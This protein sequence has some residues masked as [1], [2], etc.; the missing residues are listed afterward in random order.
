MRK[1]TLLEMNALAEKHG[2]KCLSKRYVT[3]QHKLKWQCKNGHVWTSLPSSVKQGFWCD[4]CF[5]DKRR[6][7]ISQMQKVASLRGGWCLSK[8]Y[9]NADEALKWKCQQGHVWK[10]IPSSV[11]R[12]SWCQRCAGKAKHSI[13]EM[14]ALAQKRGGQCLSDKYTDAHTKL[15]WVCRFGHKW[16]AKPN[17]ILMGQWCPECSVFRMEKVVRS[18]FQQLF[19]KPFPRA[20]PEWLISP[21]GKPLELDGYLPSRKVAFEYN[22]KQHYANVERFQ[23]G[24]GTLEKRQNYDR[25]KQSKCAERGIRLIIIP[26]D[27]KINGLVEFIRQKCKEAGIRVFNGPVSLDGGSQD[28]YA[29]DVIKELDALVGKRGGRCLSKTYINSDTALE[30][31]CQQGHV[32][33]DAAW[34]IKKGK[35]CPECLKLAKHKVKAE[36]AIKALN[37]VARA[38]GGKCLATDYKNNLTPVLWECE[39]KHRWSASPGNV[40]SHGSWCP[41]CHRG[42][43][44]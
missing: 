10:A 15:Q 42:G 18:I 37:Q 41:K 20:R 39:K 22:G 26:H 27:V 8:K 24:F 25:I 4:Q 12:G 40:V 31:R 19:K 32:W 9:V 16:W 13:Q 14:R 36:N 29:T 43:A 7:T 2:G 35:W 21:V 33:K 1:L 11:T 30:W 38:R 3:S 44:R 28:V 17:G 34:R 5:D 6:H 23:I